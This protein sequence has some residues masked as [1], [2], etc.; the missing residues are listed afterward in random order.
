M[1][2]FSASQIMTTDQMGW[3]GTL[4]EILSL[5]LIDLT[6]VHFILLV[7]TTR[8]ILK[9]PSFSYWDMHPALQHV[10]ESTKRVSHENNKTKNK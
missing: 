1:I 5:D 8:K 4:V 10:D 3:F 6:L 7:Y 2:T 9:C